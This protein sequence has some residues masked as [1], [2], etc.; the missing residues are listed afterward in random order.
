MGT[1]S[2]ILARARARAQE[3]GVAYAG[4]LTPVEAQQVLELAPA[5]RLVDVRTRAEWELVGHVPETTL[6]EWAFY[7]GMKPNPDFMAQLTA[8]IDRESLVMFLC[9][10][11]NRSH[12]AANLAAQAGYAE[13]YNILE[14][15]EGDTDHV[16]SQR[17]NLNGWRKA[18][19]PWTNIG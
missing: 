2:E 1:L 5:A 19:L 13:S 8:Q 15:F 3:K 7:P 18:G 14:G 9:R 6:I 12:H 4:C 10:T 16:A 11:G 17:G